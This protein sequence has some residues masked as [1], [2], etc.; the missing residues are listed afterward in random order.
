MAHGTVLESVT[1]K[2]L[3]IGCGTCAA[4][5]PRDNL[6]IELNDLGCYAVVGETVNCPD[7]CS[8]CVRVCPFGGLGPNETE[9]AQK[10]WSADDLTAENCGLGR[11]RSCWAGFRSR[12]DMRERGASGGLATW[13]LV[14]ALEKGLVDRV[15]CVR[16]DRSPNPLYGFVTCSSPEEVENCSRSAYYPVEWSK[17]LRP[18]LSSNERIAVV[19][20][21]CF[22]KSLRLAADG[23]PRLKNRLAL[24]VGLVCGHSASSF[25]AEFACSLAVGGKTAPAEVTFRTKCSSLPATE[26]GTECRPVTDPGVSKTV[27]WSEGPGEA[28]SQQW[29]TSNP[30]LYCDDVFA[31]TA[32]VAFMDAWLPEYE[33]DYRGTNLVVARS[34]LAHELLEQGARTGE[35]TLI[36]ETIDRVIASQSAVVRNKTEGLAHRL[37]VAERDGTE[38]PRKR[39]TPRQADPEAAKVWELQAEASAVGCRAWRESETLEE[40]CERMRPYGYQPG[41]AAASVT[42]GRRV[43]NAFGKLARAVRMR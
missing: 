14:T 10:L 16:R 18:I 41:G 1:A 21:P 4:V 6:Y 34:E 43:R 33:G 19:C 2:G 28:W 32:D 37:W 26:L 42:L 23:I 36:P 27:Y 7:S 31:E 39:V 40:F 17:T 3:C 20:L 29:F 8:L 22:A 11:V 25:F 24:V 15:L 30:C 5:C 9:I 12:A 38:L 35:I 13:L